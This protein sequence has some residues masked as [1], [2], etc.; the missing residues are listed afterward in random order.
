MRRSSSSPRQRTTYRLPSTKSRRCCIARMG[1]LAKPAPTAELRRG[2]AHERIGSGH[3]PEVQPLDESRCET[4]QIR[5]GLERIGSRYIGSRW[6][7]H[8]YA[9]TPR[10]TVRGGGRCPLGTSLGEVGLHERSGL[11]LAESIGGA[12]HCAR[13]DWAGKGDGK[14]AERLVVWAPWFM[15]RLSPASALPGEVT[16]QKGS[17]ARTPGWRSAAPRSCS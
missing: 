15:V 9:G 3:V 17:N 13:F 16:V 6:T 11:A 10:T 7:V 1:V 2:R 14:R 8:R 5:H 4:L 12:F